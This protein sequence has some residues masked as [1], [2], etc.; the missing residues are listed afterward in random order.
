[1]QPDLIIIVEGVTN[2]D[3]HTALA[4][5]Y[6]RFLASRFIHIPEDFRAGCA[7][8]LAENEPSTAWETFKESPLYM[9]FPDEQRKW[10][11]RMMRSVQ[12]EFMMN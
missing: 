9:A 2:V 7:C 12:A 8:F 5:I 4:D 1:M 3:V 11:E 10:A 6:V